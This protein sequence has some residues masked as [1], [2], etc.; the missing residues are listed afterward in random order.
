M[1]HV[2]DKLVQ[3]VQ[4]KYGIRV[5]EVPENFVSIQFKFDYMGGVRLHS[6]RR[7]TTVADRFCPVYYHSRCITSP[8]PDGTVLPFNPTEECCTNLQYQ[9]LV[10]CLLYVACLAR[11]DVAYCVMELCSHTKEFTMTHYTLAV[12]VLHYLYFTKTSK[13]LYYSHCS[14]EEFI[15]RL[16]CDRYLCWEIVPLPGKLLFKVTSSLCTRMKLSIMLLVYE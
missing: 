8:W 5:S 4:F 3:V 6:E 14:M 1:H 16:F 15:I 11:S 12:R 13:G 7:I 2:D 10:G 9:E